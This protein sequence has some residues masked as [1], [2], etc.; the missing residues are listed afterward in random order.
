M[1]RLAWIVAFALVGA[2][3][4][5]QGFRGRPVPW[6][7][8]R[9]LAVGDSI[10]LGAGHAGGYRGLLRERLAHYGISADFVGPSRA[11]SAGLA[12]PEHAGFGGWTIA[13]AVHGRAADP[14]AGR[15]DAWMRAYRPH[16]LLVM[17][18]TN[19]P[20]STS[21]AE[22]EAKYEE[23]LGVA[24]RTDRRVSVVLSGVPGSAPSTG[25]AATEQ[26]IQAAVQAVAS[27]WRAAGYAVE[28]ADPLRRWNPSRHLADSYH[29]NASGYWIIADEYLAAMRRLARR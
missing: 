23:L 25:K 10:T 18:G 27:R 11:N 22:F 4:P 16:V 13:D 21:R 24:F 5:C 20:A 15:L 26:R 1:G 2:V 29:P 14:G 28:P 9:V 8:S 6:I 19:D 12:D 7:G 17:L 3:A